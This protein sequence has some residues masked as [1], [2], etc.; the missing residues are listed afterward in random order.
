MRLTRLLSR[1]DGLAL[2]LVVGMVTVLSISVS[3]LTYYSA[4]NSRSVSQSKEDGRAFSLSESGLA[5]AMAVLANPV[6]NALDPDTLPSSET[7]ASS[8]SYEA[9]PASAD[10]QGWW[11]LAVG[12]GSL[13]RRR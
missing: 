10:R 9:R 11:H 5:N 6:N 13:G 2:P 7:T 8:S 3:T 4:T 12:P 1:Q